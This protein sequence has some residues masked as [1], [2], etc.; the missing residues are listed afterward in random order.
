M[1]L[2][3]SFYSVSTISAHGKTPPVV[4]QRGSA[5]LRM[6]VA[7]ADVAYLVSRCDRCIRQRGQYLFISSRSRWVFRFFEVM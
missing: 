6:V 2:Q 5:T 1:L 3:S 4:D 7:Q